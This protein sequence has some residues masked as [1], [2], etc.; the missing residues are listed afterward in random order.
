MKRKITSILLIICILLTP[1]TAMA[2][3]DSYSDVPK[4]HWS[5]SEVYA[6]KKHGLMR[7]MGD[8]SFGFGRLITRAEF[9]TVLCNMFKW[10]LSNP[11]NQTFVDVNMNEWYF[12]YIETAIEHDVIDKSK[13]F[14]PNTPI[15]REEMAVM[16][17]RALG[18]K[19]LAETITV[20]HNFKDVTDNEGYITIAYDIGMTKG[21][22]PTTF[23]PKSS[24]KREEA[25][26][27][28]V[29]VYEKYI[30]GI[31]WLHGFYAFSSYSQR[32]LTKD[33]DA[34]SVGWSRMSYDPQIGVYLNT[35]SKDNNEW[36]IPLAYETI[37]S[38][39]KQNSTKTHLSVFMD[40]SV[41]ITMED[42]SIKNIC[43]LVLLDDERRQEAVN[44]IIAELTMEYSELGYNPYSGVTID[45]E[46]MKGIELKEAF[47]LFLKEL[48]KELESLDKTLYVT[49]HPKLEDGIY[50]D[51]Y[52]YRA[53][54][55]IADKV[56]LMAHDYNVTKMPENLLGSEYH[57]NTALTPFASIYYALKAITDE[58][59]GVSDPS[60]IGLAISFSSVGWQLKDSKLASVDSVRP[61]PS[62][63]YTRLKDGAKMGYSE[64]Y[65][66][67]YITYTTEDGTEILLWYEDERSVNDKLQLAKLFGIK[68]VSLWR[69]GLIPNYDDEGIYYNVFDSIL[70]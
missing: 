17:V 56:I 23:E 34:V 43:E 31:D 52:D 13:H 62:T 44:A 28:L 70:N 69:I 22:S 65:R 15:T 67:P 21:T 30:A 37:I 8:G 51:A 55:E 29:R 63:I 20:D 9:V 50:Y 1:I 19:T 53:I 27:M 47:T 25:A 64:I 58:N 45:F 60:K 54:G 4:G 39:F 6:A 18:Y 10:S 12:P 32:E 26:A 41:R 35:T 33:M 61:A 42:G 7:G 38:Y 40:T 3:S 68:G 48:S 24:A 2:D 11:G 66:N 14:Y 49:V 46:G 36:H 57:R 16:L 5:E 59:T